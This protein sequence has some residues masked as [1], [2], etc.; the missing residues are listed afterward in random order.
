M[1][2]KNQF[3]VQVQFFSSCLYWRSPV[4]DQ[5]S[6][7]RD[8][9]QSVLPPSLSSSYTHLDQVPGRRTS[10]WSLELTERRR[11]RD[12]ETQRHRD[13][14]TMVRPC[15]SHTLFLTFVSNSGLSPPVVSVCCLRLLSPSVVSVSSQA[16]FLTQDQINGE[17]P[18]PSLFWTF[19]L[20]L[21]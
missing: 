12:T 3:Q 2:R 13:T 19:E 7:S 18:T 14:E 5:D 1:F 21:S 10:G 6:V 11:H 20:C 16:K 4:R 17:T 9:C 8:G 15:H